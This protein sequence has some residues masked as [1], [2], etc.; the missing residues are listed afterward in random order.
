MIEK[1][2]KFYNLNQWFI[3]YSNLIQATN[4]LRTKRYL[5]L[6]FDDDFIKELIL[7]DNAK[8]TLEFE[9]EMNKSLMELK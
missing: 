1:S 9:R 7:L 5:S 6:K 4:Y 3:N 8:K 2:E